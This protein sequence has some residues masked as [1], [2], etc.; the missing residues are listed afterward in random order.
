LAK[1]CK[2]LLLL[3]A[4]FIT[5]TAIYAQSDS[6]RRSIDSVKLTGDTINR[7]TDENIEMLLENQTED[8]EDSKL[9]EQMLQLEANPVDINS[10]GTND[11]QKIP[12]ID[13][14][15]ATKIL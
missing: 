9:L 8:A 10:A 15:N 11:L 7:G 3:I 5:N 2:Y 12:Y 1:I 6:V 4:V 13:A 14:I